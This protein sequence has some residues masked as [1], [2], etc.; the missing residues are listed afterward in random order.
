M[1]IY[2]VLHDIAVHGMKGDRMAL[3][4]TTSD[5][6]L[7]GYGDFELQGYRF[8]S[9]QPGNGEAAREFVIRVYKGDEKVREDTVPMMYDNRWGV[10]VADYAALE[11]K[12]EEIIKE[13]GL[14]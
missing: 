1:D 9:W 6:D 14:R 10:D 11:A 13:M 8:E 4:Y 12:T 2:E 7:M 5:G 3:D